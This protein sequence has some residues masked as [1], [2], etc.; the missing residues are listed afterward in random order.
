MYINHGLL[1]PK[2]YPP[3]PNTFYQ[4]YMKRRILGASWRGQWHPSCPFVLYDMVTS[5][6]Y[7]DLGPYA[8]IRCTY[9]YIYTQLYMYIQCMYI[10]IAI[11]VYIYIYACMYKYIYIYM[12]ICILLTSICI[13]NFVVSFQ[14]VCNSPFT[15]PREGVLQR[16]R[17]RCHPS[18]RRGQNRRSSGLAKSL[19]F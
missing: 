3:N 6:L 16:C 19:G 9:I 11:C 10:H 7:H 14:L 4:M 18:P 8:Y 17:L 2:F 12:Y 5:C 13:P 1:S 15:P